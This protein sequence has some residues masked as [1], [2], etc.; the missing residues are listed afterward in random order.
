MPSISKEKWE[1]ILTIICGTSLVLALAAE[2]FA[3]SPIFANALYL[4]SYLSGG[5]IGLISSIASLKKFV[6][7]VDLLMILAALGA[8]YVG[9]AFEGAMLLFLFSLSNSLQSHALDRSRKAIKELMKLRPTTALCQTEDGFKEQS[10]EEIPV[11]TVIRLRPGDRVPLDG[12]IESGDASVDQS[13]LTGES[14]PINKSEG[15]SIFAGSINQT[16]SLLVRVT[17]LAT[18]STIA[19]IITMVETAQA[20][21]AV[22]ERFLEKAERYYALGVILL[23]LALIILPPALSDISFTD[24]F[25][26]AMTVMVVA[27]PCALIISTPAAFLSAIAGAAKRG[28]L[29][30]GGVHLERLSTVDTIAFDKTGTLTEGTVKVQE[31]VSFSEF[32]ENSDVSKEKREHL[33]QIAA[34]VESHSEHPIARAIEQRAKEESLETLPTRSFKA[35]AGKGASAVVS[36]FSYFIGNPAY[37]SNLAKTI[38]DDQQRL[39]DDTLARGQTVILIAKLDKKERAE[40]IL[41]FVSVSDQ[42][43]SDAKEAIERLREVGIQKVVMLTGDAKEVAQETA[44]KVGIDEFHAEL[45]PEDKLR[46]I[47]ELNKSG[48]VAMVGDG[49]NDAPA[50][51]ASTVGIAMGAAGT[52]VAMETADVVLMSNQLDHIVQAVALARK[53]RRI[54][55]QNLTFAFAVIVVLVVLALTIGIPLPLGVV[56][57]EGSTVLV[58]L[59]GLRLLGKGRI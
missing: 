3:S 4:V 30:K 43:R 45:L 34:S 59:N 37:V 32:G 23:T 47:E 53:S 33:L 29:F 36:E 50:L 19:R 48:K 13:T 11:G 44:N 9:A 14:L 46:I 42:L 20:R 41:G 21:K 8:A 25:Y 38:P 31:V 2:H 6:F 24:S 39:I 52:D 28:V 12:I 58:C 18:E 15:D 1:Q 5:Y 54:V 7:D 56:G 49:V 35:I 27:S 22:T 51:A 16:G 17:K 10:I 26:R 55:L 40:K 57:H